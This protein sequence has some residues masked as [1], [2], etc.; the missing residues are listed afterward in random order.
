MSQIGRRITPC[1]R[2][3]P[4]A[5]EAVNFSVSFFADSKRSQRAMAGVKRLTTVR[6]AAPQDI[7]L[8]TA[9]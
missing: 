2:F 5:E 1:L 8:G 4:Q 7:A 3:D 6:R 9:V